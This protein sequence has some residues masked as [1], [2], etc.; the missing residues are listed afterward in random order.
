M[1]RSAPLLLALAASPAVADIAVFAQPTTATDADVGLG[2][3]SNAE[4]RVRKNYKHAD[5]FT[6]AEAAQVSRVV[7]WGQSSLHTH[8][9]LTNFD[10][11]QVEIFEADSDLPGALVHAETIPLA[12][13]NAA[14]TGRETP[15]GAYEYRHDAALTAPVALE[16]GR[17]YFL[18]VS[19]GLIETGFTSD[20][21]QWQ[22]ADLHDGWSATYSWAADTWTG[23]QDSD[24]AFVLYAVPAPATLAPL[25]GLA[26][27]RRRR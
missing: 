11:F 25:A 12:L 27:L 3:Y 22:D 5:D 8:R 4:P 24:S 15:A 6:L 13:T 18:A 2:W 7:W 19:A 21:W 26:F 14:A 1:H 10:S 20:A 16:A 23:Y 17:R 9:D